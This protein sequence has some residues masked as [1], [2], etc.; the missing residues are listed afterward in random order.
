MIIADIPRPVLRE[1]HGFCRCVR[2][3]NALIVEYSYSVTVT[4][5]IPIE[6]REINE[7]QMQINAKS[8]V[9]KVVN[10]FEPVFI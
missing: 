6:K 7:T 10:F 1:L 4:I 8:T 5:Y 3:I 2:S 9:K